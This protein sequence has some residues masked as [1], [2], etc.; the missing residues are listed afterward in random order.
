MDLDLLLLLLL[1]LTTV[2]KSRHISNDL[3]MQKTTR[4]KSA[5]SNSIS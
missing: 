4:E 2:M 5:R 1:L 3:A